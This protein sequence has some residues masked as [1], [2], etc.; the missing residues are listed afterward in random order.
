MK[1]QSLPALRC[2]VVAILSLLTVDFA[3]A[4]LK[5]YENFEG[6]AAGALN[7]R[8]LG[9]GFAGSWVSE[10]SA[11]IVGGNMSY[12]A[13][14]ISIN[15]GNAFL[16]FASA[17][18]TSVF[19]RKIDTSVLQGGGDVYI[20][21]LVRLPPSSVKADDKDYFM[22]A[23]SDKAD[24]A[25]S[26]GPLYSP[27]SQ[28][29][30][31]GFGIRQ[32][33]NVS[34]N[35]PSAPDTIHLVVIKL[36]KKDMDHYR[37]ASLIVDPETL[38]EPDGERW[39]ICDSYLEHSDNMTKYCYLQG[40]V[41]RGDDAQKCESD[42]VFEIDELRISSSWA[43]AVGAADYS[44][45]AA[46]PYFSVVMDGLV[47]RVEIINRIEDSGITL[48][49]TLD[50]SDPAPGSAVRYENPFEVDSDTLVK[51]VAVDRNG[52]TSSV[53]EVLCSF[54][55]YWTGGDGA[56]GRDWNNALNWLSESGVAVPPDGRHV[57]FGQN[58]RS[59]EKERHKTVS[60]DTSIRS[61]DFIHTHKDETAKDHRWHHI[62]IEEGSALTVTGANVKGRSLSVAPEK[63][64]NG[65]VQ[66]YIR[67]SGGGKF[68]VSSPDSEF[69]LAT[70]SGNDRGMPRMYCSE[71]S[72]F[73]AE[74]K[75]VRIGVG[76]RTNAE[77]ELPQNAGLDFP[78][79]LCAEMIAVGDSRGGGEVYGSNAKGQSVLRLGNLN[80]L[81]ADDIYIGAGCG[82]EKLNVLGGKV[83]FPSGLA[84]PGK[85]RI[86]GKDGEGRA[87][88]YIGGHGNAGSTIRQ[89][90]SELTVSGHSLDAAVG[91]MVIAS[92]RQGYSGSNKG[93]MTGRFKMDAGSIEM[94]VF[95]NAAT[96]S[97]SDVRAN[98]CSGGVYV[99]G[100]SF[101]V[102]GD[103]MMGI[104]A[105][106]GGSVDGSFVLDGGNAFFGGD[107]VL[108]SHLGSATNV[109]GSV[110][111]SNGTMTVLGNLVSGAV[112][113]DSVVVE[114]KDA[115]VGIRA[116]VT[117][118]GG[119]LAVTNALGD[120]E[121]RLEKGTLTLAGGSVFADN[122]VM[123]NEACTVAVM[124]SGS[125]RPAIVAEGGEIKLGGSLDVAAEE[126]YRPSGTYLIASGGNVSGRFASVRLPE[127]YKVRYGAKGVSVSRGG[128]EVKIR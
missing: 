37:Y 103:S 67:F 93:A 74:V 94:Q 3:F 40:F 63:T 70:Q 41:K 117:A 45:V 43:D 71:L 109:A 56:N 10:S 105:S 22:V 120:S 51:A 23:L 126:G 116:D 14:E 111:V 58:D 114:N 89:V 5:V 59:K 91:S 68:I 32:K 52:K 82:E 16:R 118:V 106:G 17:G 122:F 81:F 46:T 125:Y 21:M 27:F 44:D 20:S 47:Q 102:S 92:A 107:V 65:E 24:N 11:S 124:L 90:L 15:G 62:R 7:A 33:G 26:F 64:V 61:L 18:K 104:N 12:S 119:V 36:S 6:A 101:S 78:N 83:C 31:N 42:D 57:V 108:A 73:K 87:N 66:S 110:T 2:S 80:E 19:S 34:S 1:Y 4:E 39:T 79:R 113:A 112:G 77:L 49:Y 121:L 35:R 28:G 76:S 97:K 123:T 85:L 86:R 127:G 115:T 128:T 54:F 96:L 69:A 88:L 25:P 99:G 38:A 13:G 8:S 30:G 95:T 98:V 50:G 72:G 9:R 29:E 48:Y 53:V 75:A 84:E 100:G 55:A 60:L